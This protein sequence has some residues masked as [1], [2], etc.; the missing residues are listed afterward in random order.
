M[1]LAH[2]A[3]SFP[4]LGLHEPDGLAAGLAEVGVVEES[5]HGCGGDGFGHELIEPGGVDV[6]ADRKGPFLVGG[7]HDP[8]EAL[9]RVGG[10][11]RA[12][13]QEAFARAAAMSRVNAV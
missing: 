11:N 5:V 1:G 12:L 7:F 10:P 2:G 13:L 6:R 9:S 4:V 3:G 8:V